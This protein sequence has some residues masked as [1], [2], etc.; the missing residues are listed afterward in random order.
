VTPSRTFLLEAAVFAER[1]ASRE[2]RALLRRL[3]PS[4]AREK[5]S[6]DDPVTDADLAVEKRIF[7]AIAARYPDHG[8]FG[9]ECG[10]VSAAR[11]FTWVVDPIDG[12]GN[13][14]V[15]LPLFAVS[16]ALLYEGA[17]VAAAAFSAL[18]RA[19]YRAHR[20]GGTWK[21]ARRVL[22]EEIPVPASPIVGLQ[23]RRGMR[24]YLPGLLARVGKIRRFGSAVLHL[25]AVASGGFHAS[26][27]ERA[28]C[29][30]LAAA[31]LIVREAGGVVLRLDGSPLERFDLAPE[32]MADPLPCVAGSP[33]SARWLLGL[34][35]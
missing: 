20:G 16:I 2:G 24:P 18:E 25:L 21:G 30:D 23:P 28:R 11:P 1:L 29:H 8:F 33:A 35:G 34:L 17:P 26:L 13:F 32:R 27:D 15:G 4:P 9:E 3:G 19:T 5:G 31:S 14:A 12:T 7:A 22:L 6:P 10:F